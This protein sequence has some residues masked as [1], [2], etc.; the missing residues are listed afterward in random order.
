MQKG[1]ELLSML[2][3]ATASPWLVLHGHRHTP[4][5]EHSLDPACVVVGAS[6]FSAQVP[7]KLNQFHMIDII[8]D[9]SRPQP[10]T[11]RIETWSWTVTGGWQKRPTQDD[12]E[13]FPPTCGFGSVF[14]PR[15]IAAQIDAILGPA[16]TYTTWDE[17]SIKISDVQLTTPTH[18]RQLETL[19]EGMKIRLH[20]DRHGMV[21][22]VGR[23]A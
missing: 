12:D 2:T 18:F 20:R 21:T 15:A 22:Q 3:N 9:H 1:G 8:V 13:G 16:S 5:L 4:N 7:G 19:L 6:S 23:S 14:Q 10:L 11:G 17:V